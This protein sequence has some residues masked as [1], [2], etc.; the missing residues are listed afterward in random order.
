MCNINPLRVYNAILIPLG[1]TS[2][3]YTVYLIATEVTV[4]N[5]YRCRE[6]IGGFSQ[7]RMHAASYIA[8]CIHTGPGVD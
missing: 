3:V 2:T 7:S 4:R 1:C 5:S 8:V 6:G